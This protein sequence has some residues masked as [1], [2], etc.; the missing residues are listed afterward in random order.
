MRHALL[1]WGG[2]YHLEDHWA[3]DIALSTLSHYGK[4]LKTVDVGWAFPSHGVRSPVNAAEQ[5]F[6]FTHPGWDPAFRTRRHI[7]TEIRHLFNDALREH[8]AQIEK[9]TRERGWLPTP[10]KREECHFDWLVHYQVKEWTITQI[11]KH[12]GA[13]RKTV[14]GALTDTAEHIGLT[15]RPPQRGRPASQH[16]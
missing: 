5:R 16:Q 6:T 7:N 3:L 9:L 8:L 12:Y 1:A 10:S 4:G 14:A 15:L 13:G 11:A 2:R